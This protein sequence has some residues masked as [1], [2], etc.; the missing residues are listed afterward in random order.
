MGL[1]AE[2]TRVQLIRQGGA[3]EARPVGPGLQRV[4]DQPMVMA[5]SDGTCPG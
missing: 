5:K 1:L 4:P 3:G 2:E